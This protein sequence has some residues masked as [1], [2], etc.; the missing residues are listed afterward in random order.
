MD[1][2]FGL[3]QVREQP[4]AR[5][6]DQLLRGGQAFDHWDRWV[7]ASATGYSVTSGANLHILY[8]YVVKFVQENVPESSDGLERI[9]RWQETDELDHRGRR[10]GD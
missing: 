7:P 1:A 10:G 5:S 4:L 3:S 6:I 9:E 2:D 8:E